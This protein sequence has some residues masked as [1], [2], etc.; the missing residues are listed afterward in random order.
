MYWYWYFSGDMASEGSDLGHVVQCRLIGV[1]MFGYWALPGIGLFVVHQWTVKLSSDDWTMYARDDCKHNFGV[2]LLPL[3]KLELIFCRCSVFKYGFNRTREANI[4]PA[5]T[6]MCQ[7]YAVVD[8]LAWQLAMPNLC[9]VVPGPTAWMF[10]M[11]IITY[12]AECW[13]TEKLQTFQ[14]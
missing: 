12:R 11:Q 7:P 5:L 10:P 4:Q 2:Y 3:A 14:Q 9:H 13:S 8:I 6:A 1:L